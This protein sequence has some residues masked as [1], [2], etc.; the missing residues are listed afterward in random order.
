VGNNDV[1]HRITRV[2]YGGNDEEEEEERVRTL[3]NK[4]IIF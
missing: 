1:D 2:V 4:N 3:N